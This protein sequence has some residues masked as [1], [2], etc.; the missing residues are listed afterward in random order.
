MWSTSQSHGRSAGMSVSGNIQRVTPVASE[1][2]TRIVA[3]S[4]FARSASSALTPALSPPP[5][6]LKS[7]IREPLS[8]PN[9]RS[10]T[11]PDGISN[12]IGKS[13]GGPSRARRRPIGSGRIMTHSKRLQ[14]I[15]DVFL[16]NVPTA[17][18]FLELII[19]PAGM[20]SERRGSESGLTKQL[21][22]RCLC[23]PPAASSG[24]IG[25]FSI[26]PRN[27][28]IPF[29]ITRNRA[30]VPVKPREKSFIDLNK[31]AGRPIGVVGRHHD[32]GEAVPLAFQPH[33]LRVIDV[34]VNAKG[35]RILRWPVATD[36][37]FM[38]GLVD[39]AAD[40][41]SKALEATVQ[42]TG[43]AIRRG[44]DPDLASPFHEPHHKRLGAV[45][46]PFAVS[47]AAPARDHLLH[48]HRRAANQRVVHVK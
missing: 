47:P 45:P 4:T 37:Q 28:S 11:A 20:P 22:I 1:S 6:F 29:G 25:R 5:R 35:W 7:R 48:R 3:P 30:S 21:T 42:V 2:L 32:D 8:V 14:P 31:H 38:T 27:S 33:S 23:C 17:I 40:R 39:R 36:D 19:S 43:R 16:C 12:D 24:T 18:F 26:S 13:S 15:A 46:K 44:I 9:E 34:Q 10:Q 41:D